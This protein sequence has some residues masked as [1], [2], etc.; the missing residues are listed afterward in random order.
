MHSFDI[1][2]RQK[3]GIICILCHQIPSNGSK[4][5][6]SLNDHYHEFF[7]IPSCDLTSFFIFWQKFV[8]A[9]QKILEIAA[10]FFIIV[11]L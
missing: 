4:F 10:V 3:L 5:T 7:E 11:S 8:C 6:V 2:Y 1:H 9:H